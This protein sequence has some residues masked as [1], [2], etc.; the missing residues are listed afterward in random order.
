ML[1]S[2]PLHHVLIGAH[3]FILKCTSRWTT[4]WSTE[5]N[6]LIPIHQ[7][8]SNL[9]IAKNFDGLEKDSEPE[10][11]VDGLL[12]LIDAADGDEAF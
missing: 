12:N 11:C 4:I 6:N 9:G 10:Q 5:P 2:N 8:L 7:M 1:S 3:L